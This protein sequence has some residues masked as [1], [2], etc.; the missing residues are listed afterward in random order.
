LSGQ[1]IFDL[2]GV[3]RSYGDSFEL[4][5]GHIRH[6]IPQE[7]RDAAEAN[8]DLPLHQGYFAVVATL[9]QP[10]AELAA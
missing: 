4:G 7:V 9:L 10:P 3:Q 2:P 1:E 5:I 6:A 8:L